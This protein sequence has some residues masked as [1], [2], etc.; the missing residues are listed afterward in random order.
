MPPKRTGDGLMFFVSTETLVMDKH[1]LPELHLHM[2]V[3]NHLFKLC[4]NVDSSV[5]D[6]LKRHNIFRHG[7]QG[8]GLDEN[9]SLK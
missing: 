7:Y 9:N 6:I 8:G 1:P 3:V 5:F 2:G 4:S